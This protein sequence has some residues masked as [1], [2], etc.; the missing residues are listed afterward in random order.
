MKQSFAVL[1]LGSFGQ[2][3]ARTLYSLGHEVLA[4]DGNEET[5]QAISN[6]VTHAI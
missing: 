6:S 4:I 1:G 2:S 3:V 5:V